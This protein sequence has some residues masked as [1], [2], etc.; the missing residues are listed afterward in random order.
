VDFFYINLRGS[1]SV[2][3]EAKSFRLKEAQERSEQRTK[4]RKNP[5]VTTPKEQNH[6]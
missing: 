2:N 4:P 6:E 5:K 1:V 3:I